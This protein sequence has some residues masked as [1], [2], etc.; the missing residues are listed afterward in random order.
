M[1]KHYKEKYCIL[2]GGAGF[3]GQNIVKGLVESG[4]HV[5]I[6]DNFLYGANKKNLHKNA[7]FIKGDVRDPAI[8]K[9]LPKKKYQ[10]LFHFAAPSSTVLFD[11]NLVESI[12][13][14]VGGF[15]NTIQFA[16]KNNIR[17]IYPSTGSLYNGVKPPHTEKA[18][19]NPDK[20]NEYAKTKIAIEYLANIY[21]PVVNS[22]GFRIL[23][24]YGP[25][26]M[27][28]ERFQGVVY[29]F[30]REM[31]Q[32]K[33]PVVWGNGSQRRD[34]I[35][36][37]DIVDIVLTLSINCKEPIVNVGTGQDISFKE[38]IAIIN[39]HLK[40]PIVPLYA[41]KPKIYLERTT[42][43]TTLL[44][45]YYKKQFAPIEKGIKE[46]LKSFEVDLSS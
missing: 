31:Y 4:A 42:A 33:S 30:C 40:K 27:H 46:I 17:Y 32:G 16:A 28:K 11:E 19:L 5:V 35:Y 36:I 12:D 44:R 29:G 22:I 24:G 38:V 21:R 41:P 23:A 25:G 1:F 43:D 13:I 18:V 39:K 3:L 7:V 37:D 26:E 15:L 14:T 6:I 10:Y 2:T 45:K 8:F 20:Q 9:K 34:F